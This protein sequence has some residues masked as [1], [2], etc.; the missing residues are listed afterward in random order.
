MDNFLTSLLLK[1]ASLEEEIAKFN[2][3]PDII[4]IINSQNPQ[5]KGLL[6]SQI[7]KNYPNIS[8]DLVNSWLS[9]INSDISRRKSLKL[10]SLD[11]DIVEIA[12][13]ISSNNI[14]H[15]WTNIVNKKEKL[16][17]LLKQNNKFDKQKII[18]IL[19]SIEHFYKELPEN[20]IYNYNGQDIAIDL[21][22]ILFEDLAKLAKS[23][24]DSFKNAPK[25]QVKLNSQNIV[26]TF[27]DNFFIIELKSPE[28]LKLEGSLMNHCVG[29]QNYINAVL[30]GNI[31]IFSLRTS[32]NNP[33]VTIET[34]PI[35]FNFKQTFGKNNTQPNTEQMEYLSIWKQSLHPKDKIISLVNSKNIQERI[36]AILFMNY[37]DA[38]YAE[39]IDK[40]IAIA[41][42]SKEEFIQQGYT[43]NNPKSEL[44]ALAQNTTL[45]PEL[46]EI[47]YKKDANSISTKYSLAINDHIGENLFRKLLEENN[48]QVIQACL[49]SRKIGKYPEQIL[50]FSEN[51]DCLPK[52]LNNPSISSTITKKIIA[53]KVPENLF[54]GANVENLDPKFINDWVEVFRKNPEKL[55]YALKASNIKKK[56]LVIIAKEL[57]INIL[58]SDDVDEIIF[59]IYSSGNPK[60]INVL[61][62][63]ELAKNPNIPI[64]MIK[65]LL[66]YKNI[67]IKKSLA[68]NI[69]IPIEI[70][71]EL[72]K[73]E[74]VNVRRCLASNTNIS[75]EIMKELSKTKD[76]EIKRQL[77]LNINIPIEIMKE[78]SKDEDVYITRGLLE[79]TNLPIEMMKELS[80]R[81]VFE[82]K[83]QLAK[84]TN[85]SIEMMKELS[86]DIDI[87]VKYNLASNSN[88]PIEI[89]KEL[90][91]DRD[92]DVR[93]SLASNPN[94]PIEIMKELY[95]DGIA[96]VKQFLATNPNLP[97]EIMKELSKDADVYI[98][99]SLAKNPNLPIEIMKELYKDIDIDVKYNL[100]SNSNIPIEIMKELLKD[101][102]IDVKQPILR[103]IYLLSLNKTAKNK[104]DKILKFSMI[105][106]YKTSL[107]KI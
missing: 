7:K 6:F 55:V 30:E 95:K 87:D 54:E 62:K 4:S 98:R 40:I 104:A 71:K 106:K 31:R 70:M 19:K 74:D 83:K 52:I 68:L 103:K 5:I 15:W 25:E 107:V 97:I 32:S 38:E 26:F 16:V 44:Q 76:L 29:G 65:E 21:G 50:N 37:N 77:A 51:K 72:S 79:N 92:I 14:I 42:P 43:E 18:E 89:M 24:E 28:E 82:I 85:I 102:N 8:I 66:K 73:D 60:L 34:D 1:L 69:N 27:P 12:N 11:P 39:I 67:E 46:Y 63:K 86:K 57:E 59:K 3:D 36:N 96:T 49:S 78:L 47:I 100:A 33:L 75:I 64:E 99:R 105:Y 23:W 84:N 61:N 10:Q 9:N 22:Q 35:I 45:S 90:S 101:S 91:K 81:G 48:P 93:I 13:N 20:K 2:L 53:E 80:K 41:Q 94:L 58:L 56:D 17:E 88:I